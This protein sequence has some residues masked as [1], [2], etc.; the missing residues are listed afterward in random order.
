MIVVAIIAVLAI[1][2]VPSFMKE[3]KRSKSKSEVHPMVT[4]LSTREDAYKLE[5]SNYIDAPACPPSS[6]ASGTDMTSLACATTAG[7]PW[8][9]LRVQSPQTKLTCSY[10]VGVGLGGVSPTAHASWPTWATGPTAVPAASWYFIH[11][12]CP[13]TEYLWG[14][15]ESKLKSKDGH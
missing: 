10:V 6:V 15:W 9:L 11:A 7:E 4:E 14:S 3:S 2:V 12:T 13:D 5:R 1:V 8:V